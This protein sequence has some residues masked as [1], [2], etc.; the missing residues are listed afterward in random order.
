MPAQTISRD[1]S[2]FIDM[3]RESVPFLG[4]FKTDRSPG[5]A[6]FANLGYLRDRDRFLSINLRSY[7]TA[8][9]SANRTV[10]VVGKG[11]IKFQKIEPYKSGKAPL[12]PANYQPGSVIVTEAVQRDGK[13]VPLALIGMTDGGG[14]HALDLSNLTLLTDVSTRNEAQGIGTI[15]IEATVVV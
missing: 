1:G 9:G 10:S 11:H 3:N 15:N 4:V 7:A 13:L 5:G 2:R 8:M 12:I 6:L 14:W